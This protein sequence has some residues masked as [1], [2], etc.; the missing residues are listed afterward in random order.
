MICH[1]VIIIIYCEH[2]VIANTRHNYHLTHADTYHTKISDLKWLV[3]S[4]TLQYDSIRHIDSHDTESNVQMCVYTLFRKYFQCQDKQ[5]PSH[6]LKFIL[7][8]SVL[9][10]KIELSDFCKSLRRFAKIH[11]HHALNVMRKNYEIILFLVRIYH[12]HLVHQ[13]VDTHHTSALTHLR[14]INKF[15]HPTAMDIWH[16]QQCYGKPFGNDHWIPTV[17]SAHIWNKSENWKKKEKT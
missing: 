13:S 4:A 14:A 2:K 9:C 15:V 5:P 17:E 3:R 1:L 12:Y 16:D 11:T 7:W 10:I 8:H 6:H